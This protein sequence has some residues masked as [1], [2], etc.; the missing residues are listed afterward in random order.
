MGEYKSAPKFLYGER[1]KI[2]PCESV[3]GRIIHEYLMSDGTWEYDVRY[4]HDGREQKVRVFEDE[5]LP[6]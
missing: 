2:M 3:E 4:F 1:V 5:L 6:L